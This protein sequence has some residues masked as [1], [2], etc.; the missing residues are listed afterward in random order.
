MNTERKTFTSV[1]LLGIINLLSG[2]SHVSFG[3]YLMNQDGYYRDF[4]AIE[5]ILVAVM[6]FYFAVRLFRGEQQSIRRAVIKNIYFWLLFIVAMLIFQPEATTLDT[7]KEVL[8]LP[9]KY[10]LLTIAAFAFCLSI[11]SFWK[12]KEKRGT[13]Q[14]SDH[15]Y[16][17]RKINNG[18]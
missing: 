6:F 5:N 16:S 1:I 12:L 15:A 4:M 13:D 7:M 10:I 3:V 8:E 18:K 14:V 9:Q 2:L 17:E 11:I